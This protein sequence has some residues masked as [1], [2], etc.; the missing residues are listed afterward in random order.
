MVDNNPQ[1]I[2]TYNETHLTVVISDL[3]ISECLSFNLSQ[4]PRF[5]RVLDLAINVSKS[6]QPPNR[7]LIYKDLLDVIYDQN[8]EI[9]LSL[10]KKESGIFGLL[11]ICD[12]AT[13]SRIPLLNIL[14][15]GKNSPVS[16][17]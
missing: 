6:Y 13:I 5:K 7:K 15:S 1:K 8:M 9:N 11:F 16:V 4:K 17:L 2:V 12:G 10:I 3:I 14:V